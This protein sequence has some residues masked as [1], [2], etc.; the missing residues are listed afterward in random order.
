MQ[1]FLQY[2]VF[3]DLC[4]NCTKSNWHFSTSF[5]DLTLDSSKVRDYNGHIKTKGAHEMK[6]Y[7][8]AQ[9]NQSN[10]TDAAACAPACSCARKASASHTICL[11][12]A[13]LA[14]SIFICLLMNLTVL[15]GLA[16]L[17]L[18]VLVVRIMQQLNMAESRNVLDASNG[19]R[20]A[21]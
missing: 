5:R 20:D 21:A 6:R 3:S 1:V 15:V 4:T 17:V 10:R 18:L 14:V 12:A 7:E 19:V 13:I 16:A 2:S 11:D 8:M 9:M